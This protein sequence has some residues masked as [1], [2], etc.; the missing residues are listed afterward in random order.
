MK[1][2]SVKEELRAL[3]YSPA[4]LA[5]VS[6]IYIQSK[7]EG[8]YPFVPT[9]I[10]SVDTPAG[11]L[12]PATAGDLVTIIARPG[13]GKTAFM[14]RWARMRANAIYNADPAVLPNKDK[15]IVVYLTYEQPVEE[16]YSF[17]LA[18]DTQIDARDMKLGKLTDEQMSEVVTAGVKRMNL[19]L[20]FVGHSLERRKRRPR[21]SVATFFEAM[22]MLEDEYGVVIDSI[23]A[24]YLQ[25]MPLPKGSESKMVGTSNNLDDLKD[26]ALDL[27]C[28]LIV[29]VQARRE[30]DAYTL[31]VPGM[32]DGQWTS[33]IEQAS[34]ISMS[35]T[36]PC[37]YVEDGELFGKKKP[38]LIKGRN[39][40][41]NVLLKQKV[42]DAN[43]PI[44]LYFDPRYNYFDNVEVTEYNFRVKEGIDE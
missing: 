2:P 10:T 27:G 9:Y 38:T 25:R 20:W 37:R 16:L 24:D 40:L 18:A 22:Y 32:A 8:K 36:R 19:P 15:R 5:S 30:V 34:D 13:N 1:T 3:V 33:N 44:W 12:V 14:S 21:I 41:L 28:P 43:L 7:R 23:F 31:P 6:T 17:H 35:L 4:D 42:G 39:Q 26:G 11:P 29:G